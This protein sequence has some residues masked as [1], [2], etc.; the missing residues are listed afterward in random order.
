MEEK[1]SSNKRKTEKCE[2]S[3]L[4]SKR[5]AKIKEAVA[6]NGGIFRGDSLITK[7]A[8]QRDPVG[9]ERQESVALTKQRTAKRRNK[10]SFS[11]T[12]FPFSTFGYVPPRR[13]RL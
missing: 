7:G 13:R 12:L 11:I 10:L 2:D 6:D 3:K 5:I 8:P 9:G 1:K 4:F